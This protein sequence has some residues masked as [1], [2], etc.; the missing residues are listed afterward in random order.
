MRRPARSRLVVLSNRGPYVKAIVRRRPVVRRATGGLVAVLEPLMRSIRGSWIACEDRLQPRR[1]PPPRQRE[2]TPFRVRL[3]GFSEREMSNYYHGFSNR[4]LWPICHGF[5]GKCSFDST[6]YRDYRRCNQAFSQAAV[7][8]ASAGDLVWV[9][10]YHLALVPGQ[11]RAR[12]PHLRTLMFW[13]VPFPPCSVLR[14]MPWARDILEGM[15]GADLLG[16]HTDEYARNFLESCRVLLGAAVQAAR[17]SVR[18][19]RHRTRVVA[20]PIGADSA[21]FEALA[22]RPG[23]LLKVH[24]LRKDL[25]TECVILGVDRLD[26]TKGILER[27]DAYERFLQKYPQY[28]RRQVL[29]QVAVPSRT[30]VEEYRLHRR[31]I[32]EAVG[33]LNARYTDGGWVP[34]RYLYRSISRET[35]AVL[36]LSADVALITPVRD[37]MNLVSKEY[38]ACQTRNDGVLILSELAG[39]AEELEEALIVNPYNHEQVADALRRAIDM[40]GKEKSD[41][42]RALRRRVQRHDIH[43]W[44]REFMAAA[45]YS[46]RTRPVRAGTPEGPALSIEP[47]GW[48]EAEE[49]AAAG[50]HS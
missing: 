4:V 48:I 17:G 23:V 10:D 27:L 29:L 50:P 16:F 33:R 30:R 43:W 46:L 34:V 14:A 5:V 2:E 21:G 9:H 47:A 1:H 15:L 26:Y 42:M 20:C 19:G 31:E 13:H 39:A 44:L 11:I 40:T 49:P 25:G 37:G 24:K 3:L 45:G 32:D 7:E 6:Y 22:R 36:Y 35:L 18:L 41:R 12:A 38:V 28:R 8:E